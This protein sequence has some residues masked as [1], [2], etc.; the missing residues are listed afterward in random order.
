MLSLMRRVARQRL[1][2]LL[3]VSVLV[4]AVLWQ[5][6][7]EERRAPHALTQLDPAAITRIELTIAQGAPQI[8]EK[9]DAHWWRIAPSSQ[10]GNDERLQRL[11]NLAATPVARWMHSGEFEPAKIGLSP[12]SARLM[13]DGVTLRYGTLSALDNLRYVGVG[14][15]IA[16]VPRQ[17][18]PEMTLA[19][20]A[21]HR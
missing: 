1:W 18:S 15:R 13:L 21:V 9:R 4:A 10:Q 19:M 7:R 11:A 20:Q 3:A 6:V 5:G 12:P 2:L 16:L 14:D 17:D 8:F